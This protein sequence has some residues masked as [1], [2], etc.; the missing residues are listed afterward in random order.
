LLRAGEAALS[1]GDRDGGA[2][3][4]RQAAELAQRLGARTLSDDITLLARRARISLG[5]DDEGDIP[6]PEPDRLG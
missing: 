2:S 3:R 5:P 1:G 6:A 4:L